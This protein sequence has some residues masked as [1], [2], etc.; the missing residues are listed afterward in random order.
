MSRWKSKQAQ[1]GT[2]AAVTVILIAVLIIGY[3]LFLSPSEREEL[4]GDGRP[5]PG[6]TV[7]PNVKSVLFSATPGRVLPP[8]ANV[9]E[10][11]MPSFMVYTVTNA[12][13]LK[14]TDSVYVKNT[15]FSDKDEEIIFFFDP[16]TTADVK[17]SFNVK[18]YSGRLIILLNDYKLL[19]AEIAKASPAPINIPREFLK[20]KNSLVFKVSSPG[21]AF[22]RVNEYELENVLISGQVTDYSGA[23]SEQHFSLGANEY[24]RIERALFEFIPDCAPRDPGT[25]QI[26]LNTRPVYTSTPDCGIKT[27]IEVSRE[28]LK[29]G[30]NVLVATTNTGSFIIDLP[31][32]TTFLEE[33][34]QPPF[35]FSVPSAL[36]DAMYFGQAGVVLTLRFTEATSIKKGII[37]I[38]GFKV[39]FETQDV[40]Y[41]TFVD[42]E[43]LTIG[44]NSVKIIPE[45]DP[46][47]VAELRA[48]VV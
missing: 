42:P 46:I 12:N 26:L 44:P 23:I 13:E 33:A 21:A 25:I 24:E 22:W 32:I 15:A 6:G 40:V 41:Q 19:E 2:Q 30:D 16:M 14:K 5:G 38:N 43:F 39:Y 18:K 7:P 37:N 35:Y 9:Y 36:Y 45:S 17:L 3:I 34:D 11:T 10:H 20:T 47:D 29:P 8:G 1:S 27:A 31:R 4:L 48:D 28:F